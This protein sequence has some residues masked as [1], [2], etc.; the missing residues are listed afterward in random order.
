MLSPESQSL[1]SGLNYIEY[2]HRMGG[3]YS[4]SHRQGTHGIAYALA[5]AAWAATENKGTVIMMKDQNLEGRGWRE[6][7]WGI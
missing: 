3:E 2:D 5:L 6:R 1:L 7:Q 4:F